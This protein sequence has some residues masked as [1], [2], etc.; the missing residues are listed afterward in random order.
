VLTLRWVS[1][2]IDWMILV[3]GLKLLEKL[4]KLDPAFEPK[5]LAVAK[6]L[7]NDSRKAVSTKAKG[8][9]SRL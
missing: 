6:R 9:I 5:V 3:Q 1:E 8:I 2:A 4:A 7:R